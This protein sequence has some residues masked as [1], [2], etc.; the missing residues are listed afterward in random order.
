MGSSPKSKAT[1]TFQ[2]PPRRRRQQWDLLT[3]ARSIAF[4][5]QRSSPPRGFGYDLSDEAVWITACL[6]RR[7]EG[8]SPDTIFLPRV[9]DPL[10]AINNWK[11]ISIHNAIAL[12]HQQRL[13]SQPGGIP[14]KDSP[15]GRTSGRIHSGSISNLQLQN[16]SSGMC[17]LKNTGSD[18]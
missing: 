16:G 10:R 14:C 9:F 8:W 1:P 15:S 17:E 5:C 13:R 4:R 11:A 7:H 18:L 3:P 12:S 2:R 6:T